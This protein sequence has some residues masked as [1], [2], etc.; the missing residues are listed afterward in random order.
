MHANPVKNG[1]RNI[2]KIDRRA[3]CRGQHSE[4]EMIGDVEADG[5]GTNGGGRGAGA[6]RLEAHDLRLEGEVR[7]PRRERRATAAAGQGWNSPAKEYIDAVVV[8]RPVG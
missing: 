2:Q 6:W 1:R 8:P 3:S 5:S 4:A 7:R